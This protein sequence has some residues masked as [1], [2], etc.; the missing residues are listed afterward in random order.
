[1]SLSSLR[2]ALGLDLDRRE[3]RYY[4]LGIVICVASLALF[5]SDYS[6]RKYFIS[7]PDGLT[8]ERVGFVTGPD[9]IDLKRSAA[10]RQKEGDAEFR[11]L[12]DR[13]P[14]FNQDT[15]V[16]SEKS[17]ATLV[18]LDG[19]VIQLGPSSMVKLSFQPKILWGL[20]SGT[21]SRV[22]KVELISGNISGESVTGGL[23]IVSKTET[24]SLAA[25][26]QATLSEAAPI[27][28][29]RVAPAKR[30]VPEVIQKPIPKASPSPIA[31]ATPE[32][33]INAMIDGLSPGDGARF[34]VLSGS[35]VA[36]VRVPFS[37]NVITDADTGAGSTPREVGIEFRVY[38]PILKKVTKKGRV[39]IP[40][41]LKKQPY[42]IESMSVGGGP[43]K[44]SKTILHPG[45]FVWEVLRAD[46]RPL[47]KEVQSTFVVEPGFEGIFFD[48]PE[49]RG[50][51]K[52]EVK[53]GW[54]KYPQASKYVLKIGKDRSF[55]VENANSLWVNPEMGAR[56]PFLFRVFSTLPTGFLVYS[57]T[58]KFNLE[59]KPP[60]L[61]SPLDGATEKIDRNGVL[62]TWSRTQ[63]SEGFKIEISKDTDFQT[64]ETSKTVVENFYVASKM[65][66]GQYYWRVISLGNG[67]ESS[68]SPHQRVNI[69]H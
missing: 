31:S 35:Q 11:P 28:K 10:T 65:R 59:L 20:G 47:E 26:Q 48:P 38:G 37:W 39:E 23:A 17:E 15:I 3:I 18:L 55:K 46:G 21:I 56:G 33:V 52:L 68:P 40:K 61:V 8:L 13:E 62:F 54:S 7:D 49:V 69:K 9:G 19:S 43:V 67:F 58:R 6:F 25:N 64:V 44:I 53:I 42:H 27:P 36:E 16:T 41:D 32:P 66:E 45:L 1:M 50:K 12:S 4:S 60:N 30:V 51:R 5:A 29:I 2:S 57:P 63:Y 14:L 22:A 24:I 34:G